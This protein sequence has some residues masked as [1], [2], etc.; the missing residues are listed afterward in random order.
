MKFTKRAYAK[1]RQNR[2]ID[3]REDTTITLYDHEDAN[4]LNSIPVSLLYLLECHAFVDS[5]DES[6]IL[7]C[8]LTAESSDLIGFVKTYRDMLS[9]TGDFRTPMKFT[10]T[11]PKPVDGIPPV[12]YR[13]RCGA[14]IWPDTTQRRINGQPENNA[15]HYRRILEIYKNNPDP[16]SCHNR[17]Q[18]FKYVDQDQLEYKHQSNR[19]DILRTLKLKTE[20]QPTFDLTELNQ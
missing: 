9:K 19:A 8:C 18:R 13:P 3:D 7:K 16:L 11:S 14:L 17:G 15:E 2:P 10:T 12:S 5:M 4:E 1:V 20:T 6:D